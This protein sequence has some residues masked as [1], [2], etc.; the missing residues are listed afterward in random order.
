MA[1]DSAQPAGGG[2]PG[3]AALEEER[4]QLRPYRRFVGVVFALSIVAICAFV[5]RG[6]VRHLDRMPSIETFKKLES[7][8]ERALL[9]CAEDLDR[10]STRIRREAGKVLTELPA[11]R[12]GGTDQWEAVASGFEQ[13]RLQIVARCRLDEPGGDAAAK[14]LH[15]AAEEIEALLRSYSLLYARHREDGQKSAVRA[16]DAYQRAV[17]ALRSR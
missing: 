2:T 14:D 3:K 16:Y 7:V 12:E 8:D 13:E 4:R 11:A 1:A 5:L 6:I 10:L 15:T 17:R 9:A